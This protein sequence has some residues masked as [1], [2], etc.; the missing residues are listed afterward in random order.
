MSL[1]DVPCGYCEACQRLVD[2]SE[3]GFIT[4]HT[5]SYV[6]YGRWHNA[7]CRGSGERPSEAPEEVDEAASGAGTEG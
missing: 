7:T 6:E 1:D 3:E 5:R 2:L 4:Q